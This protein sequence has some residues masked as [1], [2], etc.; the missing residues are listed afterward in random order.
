MRNAFIRTILTVLLILAF[1]L[2]VLAQ[3]EVIGRAV[4]KED[5]I[6][7]MPVFIGSIIVVLVVDAFF[8]VPI[9][10]KNNRKHEEN[11]S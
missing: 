8:I 5:W 7:F 4:T 11:Q 2:P 6:G 9:F 1:A 10:R 3:D